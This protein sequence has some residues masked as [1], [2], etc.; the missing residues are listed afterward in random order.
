M[1]LFYRINMRLAGE[2]HG[3]RFLLLI[4]VC[5]ACFAPGISA[6]PPIDRDEA[7]FVQATKQMTESGDYLD[8][9]FQDTPRYKK[10]IGIYWLQSAALKVT[11]GDPQT[12]I[13][14][15]RLVSILGAT[16]SVLCIAWLAAFMF[17]GKAALISGLF[18]A[19]IFMLCFE[20]RIAKTDAALLACCVIAQ[21]ALARAYVAHRNDRLRFEWL[22]FWSALGAGI[23]IKGPVA[24]LLAALTCFALFAFDRDLSWFKRLRPVPGLAVLAL[25]AAPWLIAITLKSG[26]AFWAEAV[27]ND[28]LG[29][30]AEGQES[31]GAPP[32]Y[33]ALIFPLFVWPLPVIAL[34]GGLAALSR[35]KADKRLRFLFAWYAPWWILIE[36]TPTKLPHYIL[37]AYPALILLSAWY[38]CT[39]HR[40]ST[41]PS[42]H[43]WL[44]NLTRLGLVLASAAVA[45]LAVGLPI[46]ATGQISVLGALA[47]LAALA[48]GFVGLNTND[49]LASHPALLAAP[50]AIGSAMV[51]AIMAW[52]V[53]PR[54]DA[55]WPSRQVAAAFRNELANCAEPRLVSAGFHEPSLVMLAGTSTMLTDGKGAA[56]A[57]AKAPNCTIAAVIESEKP[58]FVEALGAALPGLV[59]R[60]EINAV[61]YSKG[62][63]INISLYRLGPP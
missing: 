26:G 45:A 60:K 36:L 47:A 15:Y 61:N 46:Y 44:I 62:K 41:A 20:A 52:H 30:V 25:L 19:S 57:I 3:W 39:P 11:G 5:L 50:L 7:R 23:L 29:K 54:A 56:E 18:A 59:M 49:R 6:L 16:L 12:D 28:L 17:G 24:P 63:A 51:W 4:L 21:A 38:L 33:Y 22:A 58:A 32:G 40:Q 35:F 9:R 1:N 48:T 37:P 53:L 43:S 31:H 42:W 14:S 13:W 10:P 55:L 27:G 8:I 2:E 34:Q